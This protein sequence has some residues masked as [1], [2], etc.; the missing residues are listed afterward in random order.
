MF[1]KGNFDQILAIMNSLIIVSTHHEILPFLTQRG[2]SGDTTEE[3]FPDIGKD[4]HLR[5]TG[6]GVPG[7]LVQLASVI[8]NFKPSQI[9]QLGFAG[10]YRAKFPIGKLVEV[11]R[12]CF[13]DLGI[14]DRGDFI[15]IHQAMPGVPGAYDWLDYPANSQLPHMVG[16]TVNAG[17][18]SNERIAMIRKVWNPD[19]ETME[20]A[21]AMLFSLKNNIPF[22]QIRVISNLVEPRNT[23][24]WDMDLAA[25][26]LSDWLINYL[27]S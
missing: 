23:K 1:K 10:S 25:K 8:Q 27:D 26:N 9:L 17:T 24:L 6:V 22:T 7:T 20:G 13:A 12:D 4:T 14:D 19:V 21:A 5:I 2:I 16:V 11:N 3:C 15:P 18:G